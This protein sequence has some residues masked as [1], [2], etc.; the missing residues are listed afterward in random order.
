[1]V[2]KGSG[3][4]LIAATQELRELDINYSERVLFEVVDV[5]ETAFY[6]AYLQI[7]LCG[8]AARVIHGNKRDSKDIGARNHSTKIV[9]E[10]R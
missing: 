1:M 10:N 8:M 3:T 5:D 2:S 9:E 4:L 6:M 7:S